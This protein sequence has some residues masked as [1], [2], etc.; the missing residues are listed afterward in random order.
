MQSYLCM[1]AVRLLADASGVEG[2]GFSIYLHCD[3][4]AHHYLKLLMDSIFGAGNFRN[5]IIWRREPAAHNAGSDRFGPIHD[6]DTVLRRR[7]S[8]YKL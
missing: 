6:D 2:F 8:D 4:T 3:P 7:S 5:E 1:M